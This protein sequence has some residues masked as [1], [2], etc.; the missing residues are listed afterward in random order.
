MSYLS[1][2]SQDI[3]T[4]ADS[5]NSQ[6]ES[7]IA[8]SNKGKA[9]FIRQFIL[10]WC[11][12]IIEEVSYLF[13]LE[14]VV[15]DELFVGSSD[16]EVLIIEL[17]IVND[18]IVFVNKEATND[19]ARCIH[20]PHLGL[21][22]N[23]DVVLD[24][25][26]PSYFLAV[27]IEVKE[28]LFFLNAEAKDISLNISKSHNILIF[29]DSDWSDLIIMI[30]EMLLIV[31]HIADISKHLDWTIPWSR[32]DGLAF[33]HIENVDNGVIVSREGL[34]FAAVNDVEDVDV[35]VP[36]PDLNEEASTAKTSSDLS[37]TIVLRLN[38]QIL[39]DFVQLL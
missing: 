17:Y 13:L 7:I 12:E 22:C 24:E 39:N 23:D 32:D 15:E 33:G 38:S 6:E 26:H 14:N 29:V 35:I 9:F 8:W 4:T 25:M 2:G 1:Y 28:L 37:I 19:T 18:S 30:V 21:S 34:R 10:R 20:H 5:S 3:N 31:Q 16:E 27:H 11:G 36:C